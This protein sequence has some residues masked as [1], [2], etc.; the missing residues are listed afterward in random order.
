MLYG[1]SQFH[2]GHE[3]RWIF[4]EDVLQEW[5]SPHWTF[6]NPEELSYLELHFPFGGS[7]CS[8]TWIEGLEN[9]A[10]VQ[11]FLT[12]IPDGPDSDDPMLV[13]LAEYLL[14]IDTGFGSCT[15]EHLTKP[16]EEYTQ[17]DKRYDLAAQMLNDLKQVGFEF[18]NDNPFYGSS[19]GMRY[20]SVCDAWEQL[21]QGN[22]LGRC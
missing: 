10:A 19:A 11:E 8:A 3:Y 13:D 16:L 6:D 17:Y 9:E 2:H 21:C 5:L 22:N 20:N 12:R 7:N 14:T 15:A 1:V 18:D 4:S